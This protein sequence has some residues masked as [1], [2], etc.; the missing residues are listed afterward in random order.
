VHEGVTFSEEEERANEAFRE[1][2]LAHRADTHHNF[3]FPN[4]LVHREEIRQTQL[5][6]IL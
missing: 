6:K 5:Y 2:L 3:F 1:L 4:T